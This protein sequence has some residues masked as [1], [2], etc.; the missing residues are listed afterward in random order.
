MKVYVYN[1]IQFNEN[2]DQKY[3]II[4]KEISDETDFHKTIIYCGRYGFRITNWHKI[5]VLWPMGNYY[6]KYYDI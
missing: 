6:I 5:K 2:D 4:A 3:K 1:L